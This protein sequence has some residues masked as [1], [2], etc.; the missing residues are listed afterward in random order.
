MIDLLLLVAKTAK[1]RDNLVLTGFVVGFALR[2]NSCKNAK[3]LFDFCQTNCKKSGCL[4][5]FRR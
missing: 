5:S 1:N 2:I 4:S 3:R